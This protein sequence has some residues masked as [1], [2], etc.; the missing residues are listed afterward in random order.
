MS[1]WLPRQCAS[2]VGD[3]TGPI[4]SVPGGMSLWTAR[5]VGAGGHEG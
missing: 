1:S 2:G 5:G 3:S 4:V